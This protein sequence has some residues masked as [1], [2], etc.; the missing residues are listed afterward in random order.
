MSPRIHMK[1]GP[2]DQAPT[3]AEPALCGILGA[4]TTSEAWVTCR[5]CLVRLASKAPRLTTPTA[6][7]TAH[8]PDAGIGIERPAVIGT[9]DVG[10][11]GARAIERSKCG[12]LDT[13]PRARFRSWRALHE[14]H[15]RVVDDGSPVRST[16]DPERFGGRVAT[17][18]AV[19][20]PG[21][22]DDM[23]EIDIALERATAAVRVVGGREV[24]GALQRSIYLARM[25][26][27]PIDAAIAPGRKGRIVRRASLS[28]EQVAERLGDGWTA[29]QVGLVVRWVREA[30]WPALVEKGLL[31]APREERAVVEEDVMRVPGMDLEGWDEVATHLG[32]SARTARR[33][34]SADVDPLPVHRVRGGTTAVRASRAELDAW[35]ARHVGQMGAAAGGVESAGGAA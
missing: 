17:G 34:A 27:R 21:G 9:T 24:P 2:L 11:I 5:L 32:V 3:L 28:A 18:G 29:H 4:T 16:T 26:G 20:T 14:Q 22:R 1:R 23:V 13:E 7:L 30:M 6:S 33:L 31:P 10:T 25:E 15:A 12:D 35:R 19:R 8:T